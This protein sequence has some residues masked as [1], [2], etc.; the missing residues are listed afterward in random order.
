MVSKTT[1]LKSNLL[2]Y[3]VPRGE[4]RSFLCFY[5]SGWACVVQCCWFLSALRHKGLFFPSLALPKSC[6]CPLCFTLKSVTTDY[7]YK[8]GR[9]ANTPTSPFR[10]YLW[11]ST[12]IQT[13]AGQFEQ[14]FSIKQTMWRNC[15]LCQRKRDN[16]TTPSKTHFIQS[17]L[18]SSVMF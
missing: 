12:R 11:E 2:L 15:W 13:A 3:L 8:I 1:D 10:Q 17:C 9:Q 16:K 7:H 4:V 6:L 18:Y 5:V 14:F